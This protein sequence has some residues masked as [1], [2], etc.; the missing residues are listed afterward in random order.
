MPLILLPFS[1]HI[2]CKRNELSL[3]KFSSHFVSSVSLTASSLA[4]EA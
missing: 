3:R 2:P 1:S 4:P